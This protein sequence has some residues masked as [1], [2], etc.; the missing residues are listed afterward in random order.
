MYISNNANEQ[1][2]TTIYAS[3]ALVHV[4]RIQSLKLIQTAIR[5][6]PINQQAR[7]L[8]SSMTAS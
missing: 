8:L 1:S 5:M 6:N 3:R 4:D 7:Q 2:E